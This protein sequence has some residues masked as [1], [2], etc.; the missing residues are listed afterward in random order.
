MFVGV[1]PEKLLEEGGEDFF[2]WE[3]KLIQNFH[4][5]EI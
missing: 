3:T 4:K 2:P 1:T 5:G